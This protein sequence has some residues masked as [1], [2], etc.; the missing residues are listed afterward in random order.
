ML[1]HTKKRNQWLVRL[2]FWG[3]IVGVL[4]AGLGAVKF[5]LEIAQLLGLY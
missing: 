2:R 3:Q 4:S 5:L 1:P